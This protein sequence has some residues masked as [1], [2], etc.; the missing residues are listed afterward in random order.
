MLNNLSSGS[1]MLEDFLT[2]ALINENFVVQN[3]LL[4]E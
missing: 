2:G 4:N 3:N 1:V